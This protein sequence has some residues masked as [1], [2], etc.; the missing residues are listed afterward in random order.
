LLAGDIDA[1]FSDVGIKSYIESGRA[2]GIAVSG[3]QRSAE[4][5]NL[6]TLVEGGVAGA[7]YTTWMGVLGPIGTP[8]AVI[9]ALNKAF[10]GALAN[11]E[12]RAKLQSSGWSLKGDGGSSEQAVQLIKRN[13]EIYR[14][15]VE[16]A[17]MSFD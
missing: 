17:K 14:P 15:I 9:Q 1:V 4:I 11:P 3:T 2:K 5:P 7:V 12:V 10:A 8:E 6:P 16:A 13:L